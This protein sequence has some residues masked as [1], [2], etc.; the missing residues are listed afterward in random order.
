MQNSSFQTAKKAVV[1][2]SVAALIM[3]LA[4]RLI[5]IFELDVYSKGFGFF[6]DSFFDI[7]L[8]GFIMT[9][10]TVLA[11]LFVLCCLMVGK[12]PLALTGVPVI[13]SFCVNL[14]CFF[15]FFPIFPQGG[16]LAYDFYWCFTP[17]MLLYYPACAAFLVFYMCTV[18]KKAKNAKVAGRLTSVFG[19]VS[20]ASA[21]SSAVY[22]WID[23]HVPLID[24]AFSVGAVAC[25]LTVAA[26]IICV[27]RFDSGQNDKPD[28]I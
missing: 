27:F 6:L 5:M 13:A 28:Q 16:Q 17:F 14:M 4:S 26:M 10:Q 15:A 7:P 24:T 3:T 25:S 22:Y 20:A 19:I 23:F 21:L 9:V 18:S 11:A 1:A 2:L 12:R 8:G